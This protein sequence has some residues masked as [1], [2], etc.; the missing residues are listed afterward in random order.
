MGGLVTRL[1][2]FVDAGRAFVFGPNFHEFPF[3]FKVLP[4]IIFFSSLMSVMYYFGIMQWVTK[5]LCHRH[6]TR[7]GYL[8]GRKP[9]LGGE[10]FR[11]TRPRRLS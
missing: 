8:G 3:A 4:T 5:T 9:G 1:L 10:Y 7:D 11:R 6:A 2:D